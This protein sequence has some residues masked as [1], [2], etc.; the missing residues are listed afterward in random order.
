MIL[1]I[2]SFMVKAGQETEFENAFGKVISRY[3]EAKGC[4]GMEL[5]RSIETPGRYYIFVKWATLENHTVDFP[6]SDL[7][8]EIGPPLMAFFDGP[9]TAEHSSLV[10]KA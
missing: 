8:K 10:H 4:E 5:R 7:A 3:L 2:A 1:E 9:A 6:A